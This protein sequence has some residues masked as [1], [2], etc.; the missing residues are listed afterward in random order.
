MSPLAGTP[1]TIHWVDDVFGIDPEDDNVDVTVAFENGEWYTATLFTVRNLESLMDKYRETGECGG[2]L[3][4]WSVHMIVVA[5][6]TRENVERT[7]ADL[8]RSGEFAT[9]FDGPVR[10]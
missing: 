10:S 9:A 8:L 5:R 6:L 4:V 2:G 7:V 1:Y 3:Y